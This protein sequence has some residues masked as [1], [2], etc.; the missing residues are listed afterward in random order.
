MSSAALPC[1]W[2]CE[3]P[4]QLAAS[5]GTALLVA[6]APLAHLMKQAVPTTWQGCPRVLPV[7]ASRSCCLQEGWL[8]CADVLGQAWPEQPVTSY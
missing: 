3:H 1:S 7:R 8:P 2:P 5:A 4:A 6:M